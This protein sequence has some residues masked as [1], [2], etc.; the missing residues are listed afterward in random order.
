[1]SGIGR[2]HRSGHADASGNSAR[3]RDAIAGAGEVVLLTP[4]TQPHLVASR[5]NMLSMLKV[6]PPLSPPLLPSGCFLG[7]RIFLITA[8][9][10]RNR[11]AD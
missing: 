11:H 8:R 10:E 4:K 7:S 3:V 9:A 5:A 1:M 2:S 6:L